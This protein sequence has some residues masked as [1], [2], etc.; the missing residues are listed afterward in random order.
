MQVQRT[1]NLE[2]EVHAALND[3]PIDKHKCKELYRALSKAFPIGKKKN[4]LRLF[5]A[6]RS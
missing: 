2:I 4:K 6:V 1:T 3:N 5:K